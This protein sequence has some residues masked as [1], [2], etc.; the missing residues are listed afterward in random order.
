MPSSF[1]W[2]QCGHIGEAYSMTV[3]G[4]LG[5]PMVRSSAVAA[6]VP[7]APGAAVNRSPWLGRITYQAAPPTMSKAATM[8]PRRTWLR[9]TGGLRVW[10]RVLLAEAAGRF[11]PRRV[12]ASAG[13]PD[14]TRLDR[15]LAGPA[16]GGPDRTRQVPT[17]WG[18]P[19]G[20]GLASRAGPGRNAGGPRGTGPEK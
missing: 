13:G 2:A 9:L 8:M 3:I 20:A 11:N 6:W 10:F 4:A 18:A 5:L 7:P 14:S 15:D 1:M 12:P 19:A 17:V 16:S